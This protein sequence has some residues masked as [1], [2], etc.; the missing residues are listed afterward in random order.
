[1]PFLG[2]DQ[3]RKVR[4]AVDI[5]QLVSEYTPLKKAGAQYTGCCPFHQERSPSFYVYPDDNSYH[6]FG[7]QAHGDVIS[8]VREKERL[9][10]VDAVEL[11]ARRSGIV[12]EYQQTGGRGQMPR[13]ERESLE[14]VVE[15]AC[16][17]YER[18]L[19]EA[20]GAQ[21]ARDYLAKRRLG[22]VVQERFRIGWAPGNGQLVAEIRRKG[23]DP[24][25]LLKTD[26]AVD[27]DGR[28]TD[29][30]WERVT[31]PIGDRFGNPI[32]FS[33]RLLP[34]AERAAKEAGRGVGKYINNTDTPLYHKGHIVFNLHRARGAVRER[35]RLIVMEGPTDVMAADQAG[36]G[37][38]VAV[39][40]TALTPDH[41]KQLGNLVGRDGRLIILLDGDR[42]GVANSLKAVRTCLAAAVPVWVCLL[43]DELDPAELLAEGLTSNSDLAAAK[44]TFDRV[45]GEARP[46]VQHLLHLLAP[47]PHQLDPR[48][49]VGIFDQLIEALRPVH[50]AE[51]RGLHLRDCAKYLGVDQ[52]KLERRLAEAPAPRTAAASAEGSSEAAAAASEAALPAL[53]A[54]A[55]AVLHILV[56][57]AD[58][59]PVAADDLG[60]EPADFPAPW[61]QLASALLLTADGLDAIVGAEGIVDVP[62]MRAAV[63]RW[64]VTALDQRV[65]AVVDADRQLRES[66]VILGRNRDERE[67]LRLRDALADAEKA[68]DFSLV[69]SLGK[70][71]AELRR[72]LGRG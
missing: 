48:A 41:A 5:V 36:Y 66:A 51:L 58:L 46:D 33:A 67:M 26:L 8:F 34:E 37:E 30:F 35:G 55:K 13:G 3:V 28:I 11:L 52:G 32:A 50:D 45:L 22:A 59:R 4:Q 17:F 19:R 38:C 43:P 16:A 57:R 6:C 7:C 10:F 71:I 70:A 29:R 24:A 25:L 47:R 42:A 39:L 53:D 27:R 68:R 18:Q 64:Q 12:L 60:I 40:G 31:F 69:G 44:Q 54:V 56:Q 1:M 49:M 9:E 23:L 14:A 21:G 61:D 2:E 63:R 62:A 72:R 20:P 65:P 15:A